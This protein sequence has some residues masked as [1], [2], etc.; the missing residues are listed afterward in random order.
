MNELDEARRRINE[1]DAQMAA[2]FS[3]RMDAVR[4]V[5]DYKAAHG[6][7]VHDP[8]REAELA[9]REAALVADAEVR[10]YYLTVL[11]RMM[12]VSKQFQRRLRSG[13]RVAYSGTEGAFAH[14]A[15]RRL[16]PEGEKLGFGSFEDAYRAVEAGEC[17]CAVLPVENSY[18]GEVGQVLDLMFH[19][20]LHVNGVYG[21]GVSHSLLGVPGARTEGVRRVVSHPQALAQCDRFI[22]R[23]GFE[24][25]QAANTARAAEEVARLGDPAVAAIA[26]AETAALHGLAVLESGINE[27]A[28]NTT[29]FGV[30]SRAEAWDARTPGSGFILMFTVRNEAGALAKAIDVIGAHGFNM[31]VLRSR[32]LK[33]EAWHYYFYVEAEG[34]ETSERGRRMLAALAERCDTVKVAGHYAAETLREDGWKEERA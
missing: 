27:S 20:P 33:R 23:H 5:A 31:R 28:G 4:R 30:F 34:D 21:L 2:L 8:A 32:A 6:L 24:E 16:F 26:S 17:D 12:D 11:Q 19:G 29:R 3:A 22:R 15:A 18:A 1:I 9:E 14:I 13:M 10:P 25:V 7:P